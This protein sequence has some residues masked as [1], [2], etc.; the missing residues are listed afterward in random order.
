MEKVLKVLW[1]AATGYLKLVRNSIIF[2][3]TVPPILLIIGLATKSAFCVAMA[4]ILLCICTGILAFQISPVIL[5][6]SKLMKIGRRSSSDCDSLT[7]KF[8]HGALSIMLFECLVTLFLMIAPV[9]NNL[10][11]VPLLIICAV[12]IILIGMRDMD[13]FGQNL[14]TTAKITVVIIMIVSAFWLIMPRTMSTF[15]TS[16]P[17]LDEQ[18]AGQVRDGFDF[19]GKKDRAYQKALEKARQDSIKA[20]QAALLLQQEEKKHQYETQAIQDSLRRQAYL[21]NQA[22]KEAN[23]Y[24]KDA[25]VYRD[26]AEEYAD[27]ADEA[28]TA[29]EEK[30]Q[31]A[32]SQSHQNQQY[33]DALA[34][35]GKPLYKSWENWKTYKLDANDFDEHKTITIKPMDSVEVDVEGARHYCFRQGGKIEVGPEGIRPNTS[36]FYQCKKYADLSSPVFIENN[37]L[38][39]VY[40]VKEDDH[41]RA[42]PNSY[43]ESSRTFLWTNNI[44]GKLFILLNLPKNFRYKCGEGTVVVNIRVKRFNP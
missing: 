27:L 4:G 8:F 19:K 15:N 6:I 12:I 36:N 5:G 35:R 2:G 3:I 24:A 37:P 32:E 28:K 21:A 38:G 14:R 16:F 23:K 43:T 26:Q 18:V 40:F 29:A 42:Y 31:A 30:I 22:K 1:Q 44:N 7:T 11:L 17:N 41:L 33:L 9:A 10:W 39:I 25:K 34:A 13:T 20:F